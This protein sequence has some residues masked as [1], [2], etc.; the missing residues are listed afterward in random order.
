MPVRLPTLAL[1]CSLVGC[2]SADFVDGQFL[3]DPLAADN[4]CPENMICASDGTCRG[5]PI[6]NPCQPLDCAALFPQCG[7][8]DDGCG[9][10]I[11][12]GCASPLSCGATEPGLCGCGPSEER[13]PTIAAFDDYGMT[14]WANIARALSDDEM[15]ATAN[16]PAGGN[17]ERLHLLDFGFAIPDQAVIDGIEASLERS[18]TGNGNVRDLSIYLLRDREGIVGQ[19]SNKNL[20][21]VVNWPTTDA[22]QG[23]GGPTEQ[24]GVDDETLAIDPAAPWTPAHINHPNFGLRIRT[25]N[26]HGSAAA[27]A[28]IDYARLRI[29]F[30]CPA[31]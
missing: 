8:L 30:H 13:S 16:L 18:R 6:D 24:W 3:C 4:A 9:V 22:V 26:D 1:A 23:Y 7:P 19:A 27:T 10:A 21:K 25:E 17:S 31:Q 5:D 14:P 12:C 15:Y 20:G 11:D 2:V 29:H 28:Q